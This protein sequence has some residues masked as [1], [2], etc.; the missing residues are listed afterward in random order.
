MEAR[1]SL[2]AELEVAIQGGSKDKRVDSLRRI[3]DLFLVDADRLTNEQVDVFDEVMGHLIKRIEGKA[4]AKLSERLAPVRNAPIEVVRSLARHDDLAVAEPILTQSV[5]LGSKDLIEIANT[6][7]QA[8]LLA[9][10]GRNQLEPLVTDILLNR[11]DQRVTHCLAANQGARFSEHGFATLVRLSE[12]D[13]QLAAKVGTRLDVPLT[14][15]RQLLHRASEAARSR[16]I[17]LADPASRERIQRVLATVSQELDQEAEAHREH[18]EA[19]ARW[20]MLSIHKKGELNEATLVDCIKANKHPETIAALAFLCSA[21]FELVADLLQGQHREAILVPC[22]AAGLEWPTVLML[23]SRC[24][25]VSDQDLDQALSDYCKLTQSTAQRVLRFWQV[26][27][28]TKPDETLGP[29]DTSQLQ[30][31]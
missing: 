14:L 12:S 15:F 19:Q 18:G 13:G 22:K 11:G 3:T 31:A 2:I 16:L 30:S 29:P 25:A 17:A 23:L 10:S 20:L 4:L 21:P 8:H 5:R 26:R 6:K 27:R 24:R 9:I 1:Q 28:T 7:S